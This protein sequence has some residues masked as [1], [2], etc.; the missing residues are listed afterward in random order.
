[1][2]KYVGK[3]LDGRYEIREIIGVG[4]MA[5]VY[6]AY[7]T[8]D[9]RL[10]AVKILKEELLQNQ[11]FRRR[12]KNESKAIAVLSHPNIVK[13][14]DV[15]LGDRIQY[16]VMEHI[17][18]I[19]LKE[20]IKSQGTIRW[21]DALHF[22]EQVLKALQHAHDKGIVHRDIKPQN[23]IL[24]PDGTIKVTDF[25]I[26]R[27]SR[28]E[29]RTMT[30]KAIGSVHYISP[31]Q[32]R[33]EVTDE[34]TDLYSVGVLL[35]EM[36]TGRLPFDA[37]NAVSVA[38]MQLQNEPTKPRSINPSIPEGL[39]EI[40][41]RAMQK[42]S[43]RRYQSAA[44]M[45]K[46]IEQFKLNPSI[47][48][49][50]KYFV[51][52]SPTK[53]V[54]TGSE[55]PAA[56]AEEPEEEDKKS[57]LMAVLIGVT[58]AIVL[59][60][61]VIGLVLAGKLFGFGPFASTSSSED[62]PDLLGKM[63]NEVI[64]DEAYKDFSIISGGTEYSTEFAAGQIMQ[65]TPEAGRILRGN[66]EIV[67]KVS[68][69]AK[70]QT[71]E[72]YTNYNITT[73]TGN[74]DALGIQYKTV[75]AFSDE[76]AAG[77]VIATD[78]AAGSPI[79]PETVVDIYVSKGA[80]TKLVAV[81]NYVGMT[82]EVAKRQIESDGLTIGRITKQETQEYA[83]GY[84]ISQSVTEGTQAQSGSTVDLVISSGSAVNIYL[85]VP[86]E[87]QKPFTATIFYNGQRIYNSAEIDPTALSVGQSGAREVKLTLTRSLAS[88][89]DSIS[90]V[91]VKYNDA[92]YIEYRVNFDTGEYSKN[93][94]FPLDSSLLYDVASDIVSES[95]PTESTDV[96][97]D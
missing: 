12:F 72:D 34:K 11:E 26:A 62:C 28:S 74:L 71:L 85:P 65:Q 89:S 40:I 63:Y 45:L 30:D 39:E 96:T 68:L 97:E 70:S 94:I 10:V 23:M 52:S 93:K 61:G 6:K 24:L 88:F 16:I 79:T 22:A 53:F 37:E 76:V 5:V 33:G 80:P 77:F 54:S 13:V 38:I 91:M 15:G 18:G 48:F 9:D 27:F 4:G 36:L 58:V 7:D 25:G 8:I 84:V 56:S 78:P 14:Y 67:V 95:E 32:A 19:T 64:T 35:Y 60:V 55:V 43:G 81:G 1:M 50:Y 92:N 3:R 31:E 73:V 82:E 66:R 42:N 87:A 83:A 59:A 75:D 86:D 21:K 57:P 44:E 2:D 90:T 17:D 20:Y 41:L 69:G 51:D 46:D 29:H 47:Q 49:E